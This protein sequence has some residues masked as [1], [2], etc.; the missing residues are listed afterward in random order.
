MQNWREQRTAYICNKLLIVPWT[1][2]N[3]TQSAA[4]A[5]LGCGWFHGCLAVQDLPY[6]TVPWF[7]SPDDRSPEGGMARG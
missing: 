1:R 7:C 2:R 4:V 6:L 5:T 3:V